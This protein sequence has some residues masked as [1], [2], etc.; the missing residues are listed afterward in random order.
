MIFHVSYRNTRVLDPPTYS[1]QFDAN[2]GK[3]RYVK[4]PQPKT[5][6]PS[7]CLIL[8]LSRA[9]DSLFSVLSRLHGHKHKCAFCWMKDHWS[10]L[11]SD[12]VAWILSEMEPT[13][14]LFSDIDAV[15]ATFPVLVNTFDFRLAL[16][17]VLS[18]LVHLMYVVIFNNFFS[19]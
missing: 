9:L 2:C 13:S 15:T 3:I 1:H 6:R 17:I 18:A 11:L 7:F 14:Y 10:W 8:K 19:F 16:P 5:N 4:E 12:I